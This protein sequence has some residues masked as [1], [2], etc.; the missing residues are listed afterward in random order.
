MQP[1]KITLAAVGSWNHFL[2][3]LL[4]DFEAMYEILDQRIVKYIFLQSAFFKLMSK[5]IA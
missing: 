5:S 2:Q 3:L 1:Q 4:S